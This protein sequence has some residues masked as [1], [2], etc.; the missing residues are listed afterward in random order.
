MSD[1]A[2]TPEPSPPADDGG[3][4]QLQHVW[5]KGA[6]L[7]RFAVREIK[8]TLWDGRSHSFE[9]P[10][11]PDADEA[12]EPRYSED[13]ALIVNL[14]RKLSPDKR[15]IGAEIANLLGIPLSTLKKPLADLS[16]RLGILH[17]DTRLGGYGRGANFPTD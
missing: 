14:F 7:G 12:S 4:V 10:A 8:V 3:A 2:K 15:M 5:D 9:L 13:A 6:R 16:V 1:A 17:N 11:L